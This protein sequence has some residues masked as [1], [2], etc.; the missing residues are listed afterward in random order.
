MGRIILDD[1][2]EIVAPVVTNEVY[3]A[4]IVIND[5][6]INVRLDWK[7]SGALVRTEHFA[8]TGSDYTDL[9]DSTVQAGHVGQQFWT[10]IRKGIRNKVKALKNLQGTVE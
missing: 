7:D 2:L 4:Q 8:I 1:D 5:D 6:S 3:D 9:M 10:L